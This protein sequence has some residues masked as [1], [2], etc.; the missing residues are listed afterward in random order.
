MV[1]SWTV[2]LMDRRSRHQALVQFGDVSYT[3]LSFRRERR[4]L[5]QDYS[6]A[7]GYPWPLYPG[8]DFSHSPSDHI[9]AC[10]RYAFVPSHLVTGILD[11]VDNLQSLLLDRAK[12][13]GSGGSGDRDCGGGTHSTCRLGASAG[14]YG[15]LDVASSGGCLSTGCALLFVLTISFIIHYKTLDSRR[16]AWPPHAR[17]GPASACRCRT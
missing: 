11:S 14:G 10:I 5:D 3:L 15:R 7:A 8:L 1:I 17:R 16:C 6:G 12:A 13:R 2:C 9:F 4:Q